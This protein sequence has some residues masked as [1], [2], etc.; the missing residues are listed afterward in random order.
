MPR[1]HYVQKKCN[2]FYF[3]QNHKNNSCVY[4]VV[5]ITNALPL[6]KKKAI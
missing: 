3:L 6:I 2:F 5:K 1:K 4:I